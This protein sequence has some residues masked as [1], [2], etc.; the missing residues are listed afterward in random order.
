MKKYKLDKGEKLLYK[1][2]DE[3]GKTKNSTKWSVGATI[4][5]E[6]R[7]PS[8]IMLCS[9]PVLHAYEDPLLGLMINPIHSNIKNPRLFI[10]KGKVVA[11]NKGLK[12][13]CKSLTVLEE[14]PVPQISLEQRIAFGIYSALKVYKEEPFVKWANDWLS[15]KDRSKESARSIPYATTTTS[16][17]SY[18]V[19]AASASASVSAFAFY[20]SYYA[21]ASAA[22]ASTVSSIGERLNFK[23]IVKKAMLIK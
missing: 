14:L 6:D 11:N 17:V 12:C 10:V 22:A 16:V 20:V 2:T 1:L 18:A 23:L 21:A 8:H 3:N 7:D 5:A 15:G 13:G 4:Y 19:P 9:N